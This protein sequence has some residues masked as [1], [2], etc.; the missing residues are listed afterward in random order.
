MGMG[1]GGAGERGGSCDEGLDDPQ[2]GRREKA[3]QKSIGQVIERD[4]RTSLGSVICS[5][6]F[7]L[8]RF[9]AR[10]WSRMR[11]NA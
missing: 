5:V 9:G 3:A 6:S 10:V 8:C 2:P 7:I 1:M 11:K 4:M